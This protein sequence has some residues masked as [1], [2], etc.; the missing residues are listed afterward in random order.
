MVFVAGVITQTGLIEYITVEHGL[1]YDNVKRKVKDMN[2]PKQVYSVEL[3]STTGLEALKKMQ[4]K[5]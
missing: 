1:I 5:V 3:E 2:L 4:D